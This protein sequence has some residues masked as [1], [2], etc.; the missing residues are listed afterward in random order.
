MQYASDVR[1]GSM[2]HASVV[3]PPAYRAT[4]RSFTAPPGIRTVRDGNVLGALAGTREAA[5]AAV[6][7]VRAVWDSEPLPS[8]AA[9]L[10]AFR[11]KSIPPKPGEGGRYPS[12][13]TAGDVTA[14]LAVSAARHESQYRI[15]NIAHV[16]LEPRAA[17]AEWKE[18]RLTV[19]SG[20][21]APFLVRKELATAFRIPES[22]VRVI[23]VPP[24][25]AYG[26][27]QRGECELEAAALARDAGR[28]VKLAWNRAEE[29]T[30]SY[31]R[32]AGIV[33]MTGALDDSGR[34]VAW[35]H[36]NYNSGAAS[37]KPPYSIAS[38]SCEYHR[39]ESPV[40]QGSYRSLA[41]VAN[42]FARESF[43]DELAGHAKSDPLAFRLRN[44]EDARLK[45]VLERAAERFGW[46]KS[47]AAGLACNIEKDARLA[48]FVE[49]DGER[50]RRAV[51][52]LDAGAVLN[53]DGLRNQ[54][55]GAV[56]MGIGGALFEEL[57]F[58]ARHLTNTRLS[59]YRVPR[60]TDAPEID[61]ILVDRRDTASAG[62]GEAPITVVAPAIAGALFA[63]TGQRL[64]AL[65]LNRESRG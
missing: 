10:A 11:E 61:V 41:G 9:M 13:V 51:M 55:E 49:M 64:R 31:C 25:G 15:A 65:P 38:Y 48:L 17:V 24:G 50:V 46:G 3:R 22:S 36:R 33:E 47:K 30:A 52:A 57:T 8:K 34:I 26:G 16:P 4:L 29:F 59:R 14:S 12:L 7:E 21:Q 44:T 40:R 27:K 18:G 39:S 42:T 23:S 1:Q 60:F 58:D 35:R 37:L 56:V 28:P 63:A 62:F 5:A 45:H 20:T 32:P 19:W 43:I 2:L 54:A 6:A 53:P